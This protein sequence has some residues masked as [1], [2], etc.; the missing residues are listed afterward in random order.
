MTIVGSRMKGG[1]KREKKRPG[2]RKFG[3][4]PPSLCIS[5][6]WGEGRLRR[7][8]A[9]TQEILAGLPWWLSGYESAC[10]R[11]GRGFEPWSGRIPQAAEQLSPCATIAE[12][13]L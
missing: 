7:G 11:R 1:L 2:R 10:Q 6:V 3:S 9:I 12:P 13:A 4:L 8:R 5:L